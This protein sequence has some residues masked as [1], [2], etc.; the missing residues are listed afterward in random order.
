MGADK[1]FKRRNK[2]L[3]A[4]TEILV[5]RTAYIGDVIMTLPILK[6]LK[7]LYP[8]AKITFL[9]SSSARDVLL[10]NPYIDAILTYDAFWFYPRNFRAAVKDYFKF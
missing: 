10:N 2:P 8:D 1:P 3:S 5:I 4:I 6:P 7:A 9:T